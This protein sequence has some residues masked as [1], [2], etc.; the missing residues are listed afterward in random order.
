MR[1]K[2]KSIVLM[3]ITQL[4][5]LSGCLSEIN[6]A[7]P[8]STSVAQSNTTEPKSEQQCFSSLKPEIDDYKKI[9]EEESQNSASTDGNRGSSRLETSKI[10]QKLSTIEQKIKSS[11]DAK[12]DKTLKIL[13][14][15]NN[16]NEV[17]KLASDFS[18]NS[19]AIKDKIKTDLSLGAN[20]INESD[21]IKYTNLKI[22]AIIAILD[23]NGLL[24]DLQKKYDALDSRV[25][26]LEQRDAK[27]SESQSEKSSPNLLPNILIIFCVILLIAIL[28]K[29]IKFLSLFSQS[30]LGANGN[31]ETGNPVNNSPSGLANRNQKNKANQPSRPNPSSNIINQVNGSSVNTPSNPA[32]D[33]QSQ[34]RHDITTPQSITNHNSDENLQDNLIS[35]F[36]LNYETVM[37]LYYAQEFDSLTTITQGYYGATLDSLDRNRQFAMKPIELVKSDI[38]LGLFWILK[39]LDYKLSILLPNPNIPINK[40]RIQAINYFFENNFTP[41]S[42][43][44]TY[45]VFEAADMKYDGRQWVL[46]R[47]GQINFI[48]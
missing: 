40:S 14:L 24:L 16:L 12:S 10:S 33:S 46:D 7:A 21:F 5:L 30:K 37:R 32:A 41:K 19:A 28:L 43:Y 42:N 48:Y 34:P 25:K 2:Y 8:T 4:L 27:N 15:T 47:K 11:C 17:T 31:I 20:E 35:T 13:S 23:P 9:V 45:E 36:R 26:I 3:L 6:T 44:Q 1:N 29:N 38:Y 18:R 39:P 22:N